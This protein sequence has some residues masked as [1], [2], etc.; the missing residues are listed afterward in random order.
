MAE[1]DARVGSDS[2]YVSAGYVYLRDDKGIP[3]NK[4]PWGT[5]TA[6]DLSAGTIRWRIPF[7]EYPQLEGQGRG[8]GSENYGGAVVTDGG[9]LFIAA[10][11]DAKIR[12]FDKRTG[13][14]VWQAPLPAA[15]F[16]TPSTYSVNGR[17]FIVIAAGGGK[18]GQPSGSKYVAFALPESDSHAAK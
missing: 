5:L 3:I 6:I 11:A 2:R 1:L 16:A 18:L 9:L 13:E 8:K 17:Q 12:A 4:P 15:G 14:E 7:G 10:T